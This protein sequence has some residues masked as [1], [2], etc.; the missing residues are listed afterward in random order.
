MI[1]NLYQL[2][3]EL[4]TNKRFLST[5]TSCP[6]KFYYKKIK[7]KK[8]FGKFQIEENGSIK[9]RHL[10]PP[11]QS[12]KIIQSKI[13]NHLEQ[14]ELPDSIY[15][16]IRGSNNVI[17]AL[18]HIENKY[19]FKIDLKN[20]FS[21]VTN[22]QVHQALIENGFTWEVARIITKLT[23]YQCS[24]PQGA[25][26]SPVLANIVF[27]KIARQLEAFIKG[28][29][30]TFTVFVDDLVFSSKKDFK[31]LSIQILDIIRSKGFFPHNKKINYRKYICD[32]T[33]LLVGNGK[34]KLVSKMKSEAQINPR[35]RGYIKYVNE[36]YS[37]YLLSKSSIGLRP[38]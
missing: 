5:I 2:Y 27:A 34:L 37:D 14:I 1:Q 33:G 30:I 29:D 35:V 7:P 11:V 19:F 22:K 38:A 31:N 20:F 25:P 6:E 15:G 23:T 24:L 3:R 36:L 28:H 21:N 8:K 12:L 26:T 32:V 17:N 13:C 4:N 18:Q 10:I 16:S 9:L